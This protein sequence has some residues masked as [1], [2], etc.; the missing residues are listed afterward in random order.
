MKRFLAV[1]VPL[2]TLFIAGPASAADIAG[3]TSGSNNYGWFGLAGALAIG[4]AAAG[5][6]LAQ[7]RAAAAAL[8]G[9]ARNPS[10]SNKIFVPFI[11]GMALIESLV[12]FAFLIANQN[13]GFIGK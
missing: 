3:T 10:A 12:I 7:G 2:M 1:L 6:G 4:L 5:G 13:L 9:I 11:L 8:E